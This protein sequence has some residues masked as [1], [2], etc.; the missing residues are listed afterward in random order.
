MTKPITRKEFQKLTRI[1]MDAL[2]LASNHDPDHE[3]RLDVLERQMQRIGAPQYR[4]RCKSK[5]L[6]NKR[7][8]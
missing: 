2:R 8:R 6:L 4:L 3:T 1:A 7:Q 5:I